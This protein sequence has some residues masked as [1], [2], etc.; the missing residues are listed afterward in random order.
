MLCVTVHQY[1]YALK[2]S[3][4]TDSIITTENYSFTADLT[5]L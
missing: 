5:K 2:K 3:E 1:N 4:D